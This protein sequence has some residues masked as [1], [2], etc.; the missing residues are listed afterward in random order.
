MGTWGKEGGGRGVGSEIGRRLKR[1]VYVE[2]EEGGGGETHSHIRA[3]GDFYWG[4]HKHCTVNLLT[5]AGTA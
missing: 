1:C 3:T 4:A 2:S 5:T